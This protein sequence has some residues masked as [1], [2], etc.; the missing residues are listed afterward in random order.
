MCSSLINLL[1]YNLSSSTLATLAEEVESVSNYVGIQKYRYGDIFEF[2]TEIADG[3]GSCVISRFVL[4]P[5]VEN[6]LIH[7]FDNIE[8]GG[9]I[10]VRSGF[11]GESLRVE[12]INNGNEISGETLKKINQ[13]IEQNKPFNAI[14]VINIRERIRLQFGSPATLTYSRD[15][16]GATVATLR[17]PVKRNAPIS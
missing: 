8:S 10:L 4:Q 11:E 16:A 6:C 14:G 15:P 13:G 2:R 17:F 7:G 9:E 1:K 5:L 12:V 3:T